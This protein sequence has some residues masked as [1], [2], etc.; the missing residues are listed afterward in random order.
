M[1]LYGCASETPVAAP[2]KG[3]S[4]I[5]ISAKALDPLN[6]LDLLARLSL[7]LRGRRPT[8]DEIARVEEDPQELAVLTDEFLDDEAFPTR[9][10]WLWNDVLHTAVWASEYYRFDVLDDPQWQAMG[11]EP[12]SM[13]E[14][15][16]DED[17]DFRELLEGNWTSSD[18]A[19]ELI[20]PVVDGHYT[21]GRPPAGIL[22]SETLWLRYTADALNFNRA[23]ANTVARVFL[24]ADFLD[25]EGGF[26]FDLLGDL[27]SIET[28]VQTEPACLGCHASL[29]PLAAFFGGFAERSDFLPAEQF[30]QYSPYQETWQSARVSPSYYGLP[31]EDLTDLGA[32]MQA[33]PRF[34]RCT[35]QRFYEGLTGS[36]PDFA[37]R[38]QLTTANPDLVAREIV[39]HI[40]ETDA[41][42]ADEQR[43]LTS[44]QLHTTLAD[45]L[46]LE[47]D[48]EPDEG[49]EPL[50][51]SSPL[52][53]MGGGTNDSSV[54]IRNTEPSV[55]LH[56][57][58]EW[59]GRRAVPE[60][61]DK[62]VQEGEVR[63]ELERL[64]LRFLSAHASE[65][66]LDGLEALYDEGGW[67]WVL[68]ALVR[69]PRMVL[70]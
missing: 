59:S 16:V 14:T 2:I 30:V 7:D 24:C 4:P 49:L 44:E 37:T 42:R 33:D 58:L 62:V 13:I 20:F 68:K 64:H 15:V 9:M 12:L 60:A 65:E 34:A 54:L 39:R 40:V 23:R 69:H 53:V 25:R 67:E 61:V 41:Y 50:S 66:S 26:S 47:L 46:G 43:I 51:W 55:G 56:L 6:D 31:G 52:R 10:A 48:L 29:D 5:E 63:T 38:A 18:P 1:L 27:T 19:L 22:T 57:L 28:A 8:L 45:L 11:F 35:V 21:D 17:R 36:T 70:Y 3:T 32:M